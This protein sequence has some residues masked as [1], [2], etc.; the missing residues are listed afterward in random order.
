M[1]PTMF[2]SLFAAAAAFAFAPF[3][4]RPALPQEPAAMTAPAR[5]KITPCLWFGDDADDAV[6]F[7]RSVFG[8]SAV[9]AE[10]RWGEGG[11]GKPGSLLMAR[12]RLMGSEFLVLSGG[13]KNGFSEATSFVVDCADQAEVDR[14]WDK[15]L[16]G[17]GKETMC[18]WLVDRFGLSWQ[19]VPTALEKMLA[20]RDPQRVQ[21][22]SAALLRMKK[23]DIAA[24]QKA[25][26]G[27]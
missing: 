13:R 20:D 3:D 15:L 25:F 19:V 16:A 21:R 18:G 14:Y 26:D 7:Y 10:T 5:P 8:D 4:P 9:L 27:R 24:L 12:L 22:V 11:H 1:R 23:L 17:G 6:R 2:A